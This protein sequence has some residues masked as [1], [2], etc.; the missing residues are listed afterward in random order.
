MSVR[1]I[2]QLV[3]LG[4]F[5]PCAALADK[6]EYIAG[7]S[8][9]LDKARSIWLQNCESCHGYGIAEAP[10]P[11]RPEDWKQRV[12]KDKATLYAHAI[13]G[14]IGPEYSMMPAR[15]GND[16]LTDAEVKAAVDYMLHLANYYIKTKR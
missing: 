6:D 2:L 9:A 5:M 4:I 12:T 16:A 7:G 13:D 10:V 11:M 1:Q 3:L 15:G 8:V 14:F